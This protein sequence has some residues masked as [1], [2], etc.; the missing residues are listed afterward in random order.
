M[1]DRPDCLSDIPE[2]NVMADC[3]SL[4]AELLDLTA[5]TVWQSQQAISREA[6]EALVLPANLRRVGIGKGVMDAHYFRRSP[7]AEADGPVAERRIDGHLFI[8][9][10]DPP[11]EGAE[12]VAEGGPLLLR[13]DKHH[14]L[15]FEA[16]REIDVVTL[17][18]GRR[19]VQVIAAA[20]EGGSLPQ[21]ADASAGVEDLSLPPG[22][23]LRAMSLTTRATVHLPNPTE[24]FFFAN[25]ASFQ[26][27]IE[28][29]R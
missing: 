18:D 17:P 4:H 13:V 3:Q 12:T 24:A 28:P 29:I 27:P 20:P 1:D 8:H 21:A 2:H 9:C 11:R 15:V 14:T 16:G 5:G 7:G 26:G 6:Y 19:F 22:W 25:G 23:S 10:A